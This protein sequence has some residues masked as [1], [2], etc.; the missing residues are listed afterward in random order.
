M[1][2]I[3]NFNFNMYNLNNTCFR[4]IGLNHVQ[5]NV[6]YSF[7]L[8]FMFLFSQKMYKYNFHYKISS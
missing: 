8:I 6:F 2:K 7:Y 3:A 4:L 1:Y 5:N